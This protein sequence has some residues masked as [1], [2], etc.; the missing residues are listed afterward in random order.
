MNIQKLPMTVL[1]SD[2]EHELQGVVYLPEGE[3]KGLFHVVHGMQEYIGRYDRF[4]RDVCADGYI[5][6]GF[7]NLGH[8]HTA[9]DSSELGYIAPQD[10]WRRLVDDVEL[11]DRAMKASYGD[12]LPLY[13]MGHSMGSFIVRLTA[14]AYPTYDKLIVMGT[15]GPNPA[16]G[17]AIVLAARLKA[18]RGDRYVS[19]GLENMAFGAY[20]KRFKDEHDRRSWL[21]KDVAVRD[22]YGDDPFCSFH[23]TVS[24]MQD[25][26]ILNRECNLRSWP[27]ALDRHKPVLLVSGAEDPVGDYGNGVTKVYRALVSAGV[28]TTMKLYENCRH[29][30]L[31]D[32]SYDEVVSDI[33]G[34]IAE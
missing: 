20:N 12:T 9:R 10:G 1:S 13:L 18:R 26:V 6:F 24:A 16:S 3:A 11:F 31:N 28:P 27:G 2:G 21:T 30:I 23:F 14:A 7:D 17:I 8:G 5:V 4:M 34:F 33:L 32:D 25:L 19:L 22:T 15:G 29:E